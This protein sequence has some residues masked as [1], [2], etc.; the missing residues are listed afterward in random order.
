M[1]AESIYWP[2]LPFRSDTTALYN[3]R[4]VS[5]RGS[6]FNQSVIMR[7]PPSCSMRVLAP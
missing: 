7:A 2:L 5:V 3:I 4:Q 1:Q 6:T